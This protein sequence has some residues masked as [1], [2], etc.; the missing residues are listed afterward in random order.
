MSSE[1]CMCPAPKL[2]NT[3]AIESESDAFVIR[4]CHV[5]RGIDC[6]QEPAAP[7]AFPPVKAS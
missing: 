2:V 1:I 7:D 4:V 6:D 5:C 3:Y